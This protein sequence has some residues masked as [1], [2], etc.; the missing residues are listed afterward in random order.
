VRARSSEAITLVCEERVEVPHLLLWSFLRKAWLGPL[1]SRK[2]RE[3]RPRSDLDFQ[4]DFDYA[5]SLYVSD[6]NQG[7]QNADQE[8]EIRS[9][10]P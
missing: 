7:R 4:C 8:Q 5:T 10:H 9:T 2:I 6:F 3:I 1:D